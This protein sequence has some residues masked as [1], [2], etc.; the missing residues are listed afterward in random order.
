MAQVF[1]TDSRPISRQN[2][3]WRRI[4]KSRWLYL[5][6][7]PVIAYYI[8]FQYMPMFGIVIAFKDFNAFIGVADSPWVGLK[9]F[10]NF[11]N[12]IYAVRLIRNTFLISFYGLIF[13]FPAPIILAILL[14]ELKDGVFK[15]SVQTISYLPHFVSTVIIVGMYVN[16]LSPST[17][18]I[19]NIIEMLG[20][21]RTY[22]LNDPQYFRRLY[23]MMGIWAGV[24]WGS[25]I[26]LA[27][28]TGIDVEL[29]EAC[30]IDGGGRIRQTLHITLPGIA[31][32]III[33]LIFRIGNLLSVGHESIL[34]MYT[35]ATYETADVIST[36][37]YRRGLVEADYSFSTAVG[38]FNSLV[39]LVLITFANE[40]AKRFGETSLW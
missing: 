21:Q 10:R 26:Y 5:M 38:L 4:K 27:A 37:V 32:T 35:P 33:M 40:M 14:N 3:T 17:G 39:S 29:Y 34:L 20:G 12:S 7:L 25:I 22:F 2:Q 16:F 15:K 13:G 19:N 28:L 18:L 30:V 8:I 23:T 24:G 36:Y 6:F 11:F 9:H 1:T 31:P